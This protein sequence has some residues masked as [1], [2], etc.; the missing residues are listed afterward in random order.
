MVAR[1]TIAAYATAHG[2]A[3]SDNKFVVG[4]YAQDTNVHLILFRIDNCTF[5]SERV[6]DF[7]ESEA[8]D[9]GYNVVE[10]R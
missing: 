2:V 10:W 9:Y 7:V 8:Y 3:T 6:R 5:L 4:I 1:D